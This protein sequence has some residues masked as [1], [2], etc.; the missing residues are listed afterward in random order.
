ME[1]TI[2]PDDQWAHRAGGIAAI[3]FGVAYIS[4]MALFSLSGANPP[5]RK[6]GFL[7]QPNLRRHGWAS[8]VSRC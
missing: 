3:L 1:N 4:I 7:K 6:H 5:E 2:S 8:L